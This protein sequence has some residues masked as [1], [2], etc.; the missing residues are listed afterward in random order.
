MALAHCMCIFKW[1]QKDT[2]PSN[3]LTCSLCQVHVCFP[4][5]ELC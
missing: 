4:P 5:R 3:E 1:K 2:G